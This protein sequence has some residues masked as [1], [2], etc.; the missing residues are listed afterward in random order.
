MACRLP[1]AGM[2]DHPTGRQIVSRGVSV[3]VC[4]LLV[5]LTAMSTAVSAAQ[6]QVG[7]S[8][9]VAQ[10]SLA[11]RAASH[12]SMPAASLPRRISGRGTMTEAA[13]RIHLV[14][15]SSYRLVAHE[16]AGR[17]SRVWVQVK[18]GEFQE[19]APGSGLTVLREP[20]GSSEREVRYMT[21][22]NSAAVF[23]E[24]PL[25]FELVIDPTI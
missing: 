4:Q 20:G 3:K 19:L 7:I 22:A 24:V 25:R 5:T 9:G 16:T 13:I 11:A 15:N 14:A 2:H 6:A 8:S 17:A 10:V 18:D 21:E 23:T 12:A 1:L